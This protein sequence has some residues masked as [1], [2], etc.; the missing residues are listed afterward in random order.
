MVSYFVHSETKT[1]NIKFLKKTR[2]AHHMD[3]LKKFIF[4]AF[5]I[6]V[7]IGNKC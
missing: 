4:P 5:I 7:Q 1:V 6:D 2:F 3:A